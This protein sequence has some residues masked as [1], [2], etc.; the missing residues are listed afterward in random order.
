MK[1]LIDTRIITKAKNQNMYNSLYI[2]YAT[3]TSTTRGGSR[4]AATSKME[5]FVIMVNGLGPSMIM[6][7]DA[8]RDNTISLSFVLSHTM[9]MC[10]SKDNWLPIVTPNSFSDWFFWF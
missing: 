4:T 3:N 1:K 8:T 6:T 2:F 7:R 5:L 9:L 10:F